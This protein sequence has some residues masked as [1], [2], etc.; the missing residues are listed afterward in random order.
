MLVGV[1]G[2]NHKKGTG[3]ER[4]KGEKKKRK[5]RKQRRD[6]MYSRLVYSYSIR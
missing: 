4:G 5:G 6:A 3:K 1:S 2:G